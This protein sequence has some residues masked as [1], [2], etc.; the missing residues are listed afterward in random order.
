MGWKLNRCGDGY[1]L[2]N[3]IKYMITISFAKEFRWQN[4]FERAFEEPRFDGKK[5]YKRGRSQPTNHLHLEIRHRRNRNPRQ[6]QI[7]NPPEPG[8]GP[9]CLGSVF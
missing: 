3:C 4:I 5:T 1:R 7:R 8:P 2:H 6:A 9:P